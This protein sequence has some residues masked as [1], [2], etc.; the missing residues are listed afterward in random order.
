MAIKGRELL[1]LVQ[2]LKAASR[3]GDG[4]EQASRLAR[5]A[6]SDEILVGRAE[7]A[8][9]GLKATVLLVGREGKVLASAERE[10]SAR[11]VA[12]LPEWEALAGEACAK[13]PARSPEP[14][15]VLAST[16]DGAEV[17]ARSSGLSRTTWGLSL[18]GAGIACGVGAVVVGVS[19]QSRASEANGTP[20]VRQDDY[21][22]AAQGARTQ[23]LVADVLFGLGAVGLVSGAW[24]IIGDEGE[25]EAEAELALS[26]APGGLGLTVGG[27]F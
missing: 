16:G 1:A 6:R 15:P 10:L 4:A 7:A 3:H 8:G 14:D 18:G 13:A 22:R 24:L 25:E 26:F 21:Q 11:G 20:Q 17:S 9:A 19:A 27:K 5:W 12:A 23:A 2:E